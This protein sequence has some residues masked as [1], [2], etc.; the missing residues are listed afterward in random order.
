[1]DPRHL[2]PRPS[3]ITNSL[4]RRAA[5]RGMAGAAAITIVG[6]SARAAQSG[7]DGVAPVEGHPRLWLT[8]RICPLAR[9]GHRR[10][11]DVAGRP[12]RRWPKRRRPT[13]TPA[14]FPARTTG[15]ARLGAVSDRELRRALR[16][17]V[18]GPPGRGGPAG[19]CRARPH[20]PHVRDQRGGEGTGREA[21]RS[22]TRT[23]PSSTAPLVGR[24]LAP[25]GRLDLP[26][27]SP[28]RTRRRS[29]RSSCA[30]STRTRIASTT[31]ITTIPSRSGVVNDPVLCADRSR[32]AG[33]ATTTSPPT[34]ATSA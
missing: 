29:A 21:S 20:P 24:G 27:R 18:A 5:L 16:L 30:G 22:A 34:C 11:P 19:L 32:S 7:A 3:M 23:S 10:Q 14:P 33:P 8:E 12:P 6:R 2:D 15:A 28:P 13:W 9:L 1:M 31:A 26:G 25:D 4:T 17:P